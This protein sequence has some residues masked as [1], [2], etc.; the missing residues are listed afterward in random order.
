MLNFFDFLET[1]LEEAHN[2][3]IGKKME[4]YEGGCSIETPRSTMRKNVRKMVE[5]KWIKIQRM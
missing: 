4:I 5:G 3:D 1:C 2:K